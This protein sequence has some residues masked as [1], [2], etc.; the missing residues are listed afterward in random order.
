MA[1][2][3]VDITHTVGAV[4]QNLPKSSDK[5]AIT[6]Q[7]GA[8]AMQFWKASAQRELRSSSRDYVN[9]L[10]HK[11]EGGRITITLHGVLPNMIENGWPG[12]DMRDWMLKGPNAKLGAD[13]MYNTIPFRHG[14]PGT[15]GRNVGRPMP[16]AIHAPAKRLSATLSRPGMLHGTQG[17][18]PVIYGQRLF[19]D[20]FRMSRQAK[21]ILKTLHRPWHHTS[22]YM[23]M[24]RQEKTYRRA[25][26]S[27]YM[28][29]RRISSVK[30]GSRHWYHPGVTPRRLAPATQ[31]HIEGMAQQIVVGALGK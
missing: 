3:R 28:T 10:V 25:T 19:P 13:G 12:G 5:L 8:A 9:G 15:S 11:E 1:L 29:F 27:Q 31:R 6:R 17:G 26:Q 2:I 4:I 21:N 18:R 23:G 16:Q 7:L 24:I 30:R 14:T 20:V 22:I